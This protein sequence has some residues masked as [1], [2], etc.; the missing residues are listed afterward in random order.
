[1]DTTTDG[2]FRESRYKSG[3]R[4]RYRR[5]TVRSVNKRLN[6]LTKQLNKAVEIKQVET[7]INSG[8]TIVAGT[9]YAHL[10]SQIALGDDY[11]RREG[12]SVA[13]VS[14][15]YR[16]T[17]KMQATDTNDVLARLVIVFC[18]END[19]A[20]PT[21]Q[22]IFANQDINS[23]LNN[24]GD[25]RGNYQILYDKT[26]VLDPTTKSI[27]HVSQFINLK[28][29]TMHFHGDTAGIADITNGA[30][31]A[32]ILTDGNSQAMSFTGRARIRYTD[33]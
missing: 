2:F 4:R 3:G 32:M 26:H 6:R 19:G 1:M 17:I 27:V 12:S 22:D 13:L 31:F 21:W 15:A 25:E 30:T 9:E 10:F 23:L 29:K 11:F 24:Q 14:L 20:T 18:R 28:G 5:P 8:T 16:A 7:Q 33:S